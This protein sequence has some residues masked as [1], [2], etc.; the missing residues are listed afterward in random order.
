MSAFGPRL[1]EAFVTLGLLAAAG[2][3]LAY[4]QPRLASVYDQTKAVEDVYAIPD[5]TLLK[6]LSL[7]H[8][9][10]LADY[11]FA[12][13]LVTTGRHFVA[14]TIFT[15]QDAYLEAVLALEPEYHDVYMFADS[16]LTISTVELPAENFRIARNIQERGLALF[17]DDS[18][19][20][21]SAGQFVAYFAPPRLP[22]SEN[23]SEWRQAG[24]K[25]VQHACE[26]WPFPNQLPVSCLGSAGILSKLGETAAAIHSLERL[27]ALTED[28]EIR[29]RAAKQL[30]GLLGEQA[31]EAFRQRSGELERERAEDLPSAS[32]TLYQ[33]IGP[34]RDPVR[35][36]SREP[37][38][39]GRECASAFG[40]RPR[41]NQD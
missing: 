23:A 2:G 24:A 1:G 18:D 34:A 5:P 14:R 7:G 37:D 29:T 41:T 3:A 30:E 11:L 27:V 38:A 10:A 35:C 15:Q 9:S 12:T 32:R 13:T 22:A 40:M 21:M 4:S 39:P 8:R 33:L 20:W 36:L 31:R 19:L 16:L 28:E 26:I 17:P 25:M 6:V